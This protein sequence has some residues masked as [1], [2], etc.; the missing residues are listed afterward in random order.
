MNT[1]S[2]SS[3]FIALPT[4]N[5]PECVARRISE[6]YGHWPSIGGICVSD[7]SQVPDAAALAAAEEHDWVHYRKN[8]G[9]I[10]GGANFIRAVEYCDAD[11]IWLR[12]DDDP[13]TKAQLEAVQAHLTA[14]GPRLIILSNAEKTP[15]VG[16]GLREFAEN[17]E[18]VQSMGWLSMI[19]LP[20]SVARQSLMWGYWGVHT[21][22]ANICLVLGLFRTEP[23]LEF[24]VA[25]FQMKEGD[26]REVGQKA[27]GWWAFFRTCIQMF[28][29]TAG[30]I[31]DARIRRIYLRR[32]RETQKFSLCKT[33]L[34]QMSGLGGNERISWQTFMPL[35]SWSNPRTSLL[36][37]MLYL[38]S[39]VPQVVWQAVIAAGV[40]HLSPQRLK[41]LGMEWL[42]HEASFFI[43]LAAIRRRASGDLVGTFL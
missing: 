40:R 23:Q 5:R 28:P 20:G 19:V 21:G 36:A 9:N 30:V 22:W 12:G 34:R 42:P 18:K 35:V 4:Y 33:M 41:Q 39:V 8:C 32:W 7:N 6:V 26:F 16:R 27:G 24:V 37:L 25:P 11:Y 17:F 31:E 43:R 10:G 14:S 3:L 29:A 38:M 1:M 2:V 15:F 13:I